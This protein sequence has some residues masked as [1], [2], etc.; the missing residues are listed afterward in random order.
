MKK[1]ILKTAA[2][3]IFTIA[4]FNAKAQNSL[5]LRW[6]HFVPVNKK[7]NNTFTNSNAF[8]IGFMHTINKSDFSAGFTLSHQEFRSKDGFF[9]NGYETRL[10]I[11][12]YLITARYDFINKAA[13]K[14][15]ASAD[16]G[17][18]KCKNTEL[19]AG[20]KKEFQNTGITTGI[21]FGTDMAVSQRICLG[22]NV[23]SQYS[24]IQ[25]M[26]FDERFSINN[27][28]SIG[29]NIGIRFLLGTKRIKEIEQKSFK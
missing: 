29:A 15:Y 8:S 26:Q 21:S 9:S 10:H 14:L 18:N 5:S 22:A 6:G 24:Y 25:S 20:I 3:F 1:L 16:A 19:N 12:N 13:F 17:L 7:L 28:T 4:V 27:V 23:Q 11:N 2:I